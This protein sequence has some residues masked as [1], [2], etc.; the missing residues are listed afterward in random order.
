MEFSQQ[1]GNTYLVFFDYGFKMALPTIMHQYRIF[2]AIWEIGD[3]CL[4]A[5]VEGKGNKGKHLVLPCP[6]P[7]F[8]AIHPDS[9]FIRANN[10]AFF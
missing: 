2:E 6:K 1:M 5:P 4:C 7:A 8:L 3:N 9:G 10:Y